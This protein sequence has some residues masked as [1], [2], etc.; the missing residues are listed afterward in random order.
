MTGSAIEPARL[1]LGT[2]KQERHDPLAP[3]LIGGDS[4]DYSKSDASKRYSSE[5]CKRLAQTLLAATQDVRESKRLAKR[6]ADAVANEEPTAAQ[7]RPRRVATDASYDKDG[8]LVS[9]V[10]SAPSVWGKR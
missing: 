6:T 10:W 4:G 5:V 7:A 9:T 8:R 1:H 3:S 2:L